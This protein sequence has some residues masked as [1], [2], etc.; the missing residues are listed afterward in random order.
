MPAKK[1]AT[2]AKPATQN[3]VHGNTAHGHCRGRK[4][5]R[6]WASWKEMRQR[7]YNPNNQRYAAYGGAGIRVCEGLNCFAS[8]TQVLGECPPGLQIDRWPNR[9]GSYTCGQCAE[10]VRHGWRLNVRWATPKQNSRNKCNNHVL[11]FRGITASL[12]ELCDRFNVPYNITKCRLQRGWPAE[13]A[14]FTPQKRSARRAKVNDSGP[15]R[16]TGVA[17]VE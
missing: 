7:C 5:T 4:M 11:T 13:K 15:N 10:C 9:F 16:V 3:P 2:T 8:F 17:N 6:H 1:S 12:A 14:F